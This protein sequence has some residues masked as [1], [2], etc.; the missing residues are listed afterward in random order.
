MPKLALTYP[1]ASSY[2]RF[3]MFLPGDAELLAVASQFGQLQLCALADPARP[4]AGRSLLITSSG[5]EV[6]EGARLINVV[7]QANAP[8]LFVFELPLVAP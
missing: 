5:G 7:E 1:L 3:D 4:F 8:A 2:G 6:P